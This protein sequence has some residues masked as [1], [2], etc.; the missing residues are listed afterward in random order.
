M[1]IIL[2]LSIMALIIWVAKLK[3][4]LNIER[5]KVDTYRYYS[6]KLNHQIRGIK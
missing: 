6:L 2:M 4:D 3:T 5:M 1:E